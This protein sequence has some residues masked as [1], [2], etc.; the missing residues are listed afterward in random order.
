MNRALDTAAVKNLEK[1]AIILLPIFYLV[2]LIGHIIP[3]FLPLM[4]TLT[5]YT[6]LGTAVIGFAPFLIK[7]NPKLLLWAA[8]TFFITL[9]LEILGVKTGAVFGAYEYGATL[10]LQF[11]GVPLL[12]GINWTLIILGSITLVEK[13][14]SRTWV[15]MVLTSAVTVIFDFIM[16]P[17]AIALDYWAWEGGPI[18]LQNYIAWGVISFVFAGLFRAMKLKNHYRL[19]SAVVII[20][21][22]FFLALRLLVA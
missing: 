14:S 2:G 17:A 15:V 19:P 10:G 7:R 4:I 11:M 12:I 13:L 8:V 3:E 21:A 20:Q 6:I 1:W 18:P 16:E 5:P 22:V 9:F